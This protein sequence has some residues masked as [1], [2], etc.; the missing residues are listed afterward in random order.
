MIN[1]T[2]GWT[3]GEQDENVR[4]IELIQ[5]SKLMNHQT[6]ASN[7]QQYQ[8]RGHTQRA[9]QRDHSLEIHTLE[10]CINS[11]MCQTRL[12]R[13]LSPYFRYQVSCI[14]SARLL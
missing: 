4:N 1:A 6:V 9:E 12:N 3:H 14:N 13:S 11:E 10:I 7:F 2:V 8:K 5:H